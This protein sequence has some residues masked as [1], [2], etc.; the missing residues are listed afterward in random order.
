MLFRSFRCACIISKFLDSRLDS[1]F[2]EGLHDEGGG[3][4]PAHADRL[5]AACLHQAMGIPTEEGIEC[6]S[7]FVTVDFLGSKVVHVA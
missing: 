6:Q 5:R 2:L 3:D 1:E 4:D 7:V